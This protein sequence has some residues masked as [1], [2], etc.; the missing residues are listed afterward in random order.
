[1]PVCRAKCRVAPLPVESQRLSHDLD[2]V[3]PCVPIDQTPSPVRLSVIV[4][5]L[6]TPVAKGGID[7][8]EVFRDKELIACHRRLWTEVGSFRRFR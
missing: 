8:V 2:P 7:R 1:M 3:P 5:P 4:S 6:Q